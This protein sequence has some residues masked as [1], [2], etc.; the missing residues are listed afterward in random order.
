MVNIIGQNIE[1][2]VLSKLVI[3]KTYAVKASIFGVLQ[4]LF[5]YHAVD[6]PAYR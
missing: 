1:F 5:L 4:D 2:G 6:I 3:W